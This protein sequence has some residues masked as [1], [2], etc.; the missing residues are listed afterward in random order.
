MPISMGG[1]SMKNNGK[2]QRGHDKVDCRI[3]FK[4][5]GAQYWKSPLYILIYS[6]LPGTLDG[7]EST[8]FILKVFHTQRTHH[9]PLD[10]VSRVVL[11]CHSKLNEYFAVPVPVKLKTKEEKKDEGNID[12]AS[13]IG[14]YD[15]PLP[16]NAVFKGCSKEELINKGLIHETSI[17]QVT[18]RHLTRLV[19]FIEGIVPKNIKNDNMIISWAKNAA[20]IRSVLEVLIISIKYLLPIFRSLQKIHSLVSLHVIHTNL[21]E[22]TNYFNHLRCIC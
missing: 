8:K 14:F 20:R 22:N 18:C 6:P 2:Y 17:G 10:F 12:N 15:L 19:R 4:K 21:C 7:K 11:D 16:E 1:G 5:Y 9:K 13:F 3:N